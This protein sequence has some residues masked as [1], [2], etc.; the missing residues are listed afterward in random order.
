MIDC[1]DPSPNRNIILE[2]LILKVDVC[3][4]SFNFQARL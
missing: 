4:H 3:G 1:T 2:K